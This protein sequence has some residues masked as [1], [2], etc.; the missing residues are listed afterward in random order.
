MILPLT[1]FADIAPYPNNAYYH[2][3]PSNTSTNT[4]LLIAVILLAAVSIVSNIVL[5]I[6]L[7]RTKKAQRP[8][9]NPGD[10]SDNVIRSA[11]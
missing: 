4:T 5:V 10:K 3:T 11:D 9:A 7:E 1:T 2:P 8:K 6:L